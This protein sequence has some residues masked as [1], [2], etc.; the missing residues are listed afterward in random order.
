MKPKQIF[1]DFV[2]VREIHPILLMMAAAVLT[3]VV[4]FAALLRDLFP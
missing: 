1:G 4:L 3:A 2:A